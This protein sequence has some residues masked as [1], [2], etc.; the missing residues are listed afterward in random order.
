MKRSGR[1]YRTPANL[2]EPVYRLLKVYALAASAAGVGGLALAQ[3]AEAKVV[4]TPA[5][6]KLHG[7]VTLDVDHNGAIDFNLWH[8]VT[9]NPSQYTS[10]LIAYADDIRNGFIGTS[11]KGSFAIAL[12]RGAK[13]GTGVLFPPEG[14][15]AAERCQSDGRCSW[16]GQWANGGNG[17]KN[18]YLGLKFII[19][20]L[21]HFGWARVIVDKPSAS[22]GFN[23]I[24]TGYAYETIANKPIIA[25]KTNQAED[26]GVEELEATFPTPTA[27]AATLGSL[28][29]GSTRTAHGAKIRPVRAAR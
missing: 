13:I 27:E 12:P 6:L 20:G 2:P 24:L 8:T 15:M 3:P 26:S 7:L 16:A 29:L 11:R 22:F 5:H 9:G 23:A 28:A 21:I 17:V 14:R 10:W 1:P 19:N 18:R 25:G 4:Y